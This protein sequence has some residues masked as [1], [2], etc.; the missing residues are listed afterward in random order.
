MVLPAGSVRIALQSAPLVSND[1]TSPPSLPP[2]PTTTT[3]APTAIAAAAAVGGRLLTVMTFN[4]HSG[5]NQPEDAYSLDRIAALVRAARP[6][7]LCVQ[8]VE[9]VRGGSP[10]RTR[11]WSWAHAEDQVARL[12]EATGL[13]HTLWA[14][15]IRGARWDSAVQGEEV[16]RPVA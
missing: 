11:K 3:R 5:I 2:A 16:L 1:A 6:S 15:A 13:R 14:P 7:V 10:Q 12:A 8:E 9:C 4:M